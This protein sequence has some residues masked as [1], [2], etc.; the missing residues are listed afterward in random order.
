M[1]FTKKSVKANEVVLN[2]KIGNAIVKMVTKTTV[3]G[4]MVDEKLTW[5]DHIT[6]LCNTMYVLCK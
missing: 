6:M 4:V 1:L 2:I 3:L 5:H